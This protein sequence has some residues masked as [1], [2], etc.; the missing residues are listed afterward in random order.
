MKN[1]IKEM[2]LPGLSLKHKVFVW[3]FVVSFCL[4]GSIAEAPLWILIT[5]VL[6]FGNAFRL[7]KKVPLPGDGP[8]NT[9]I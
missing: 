8:E 7:I 6:N 2:T 1:L 4:L 5:L 3:Y 9:K